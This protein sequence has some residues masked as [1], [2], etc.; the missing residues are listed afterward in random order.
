MCLVKSETRQLLRDYLPHRGRFLDVQKERPELASVEK[1]FQELVDAMGAK[2][3]LKAPVEFGLFESDKFNAFADHV[4]DKYVIGLH[5]ATCGSFLALFQTMLSSPGILPKVGKPSSESEPS[6]SFQ[7]ISDFFPTTATS[8]SHRVPVDDAR[9]RFALTL[10]WFALTAVVLHELAHITNGHIDWKGAKNGKTAFCEFEELDDV[11]QGIPSVEHHTLERDA[12]KC[13]FNWGCGIIK[14]STK[15]F[16]HEFLGTDRLRTW[17]YVFAYSMVWRAMDQRFWTLEKI[18]GKHPPKP[19]RILL[20]LDAVYHLLVAQPSYGFPN[21][22]ALSL[23]ETVATTTEDTAARLIASPPVFDGIRGALSAE[24][25]AQIEQYVACWKRL[26]PEL[27][28]HA[29]LP[30]PE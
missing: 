22:D 28:P 2:Y 15:M 25:Q 5:T 14:A 16:A 13:A 21:N 10:Y 11:F 18:T 30:L 8:A 20:G 19:V 4:K 29:W 17:Y 12:D 26:R 3:S 6:P 23:V 1:T 7:T 27:L 9:R 24:S